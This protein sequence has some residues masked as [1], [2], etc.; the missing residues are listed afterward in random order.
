MDLLAILSSHSSLTFSCVIDAEVGSSVN[1]DA[2]DRHIE[3]LVQA[4]KPIGSENLSQAVTKTLEF[5]IS[6]SFAHIGSKTG[7]GKVK[8]VDKA[9]GG[10]PSG[11]AGCQ[12]S[13]KVTPEL[14]PLV[15]IVKED[16]LVLVFES[17]VEGLGW[18]ISD[19]I[20]KVTTPEGHE[21]LFFGD[22]VD[23]IHD[24][25]VL[26]VGCDLF[27]CMLDLERYKVE[28]EKIYLA[29]C[30]AE[31]QLRI[32]PEQKRSSKDG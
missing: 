16:L 8:W 24:A 28:L 5:S 22:T 17:E 30:S 20:G 6:T 18:E 23:T 31:C 12:V 1:D 26:L 14:G 25:F 27:A 3:A 13:S 7:S 21:T 10:R 2:L 9:Q 11:T 32:Y 19:H 29:N 15:N 4:F